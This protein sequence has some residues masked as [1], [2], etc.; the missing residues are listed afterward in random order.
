MIPIERT[1][2]Y[3]TYKQVFDAYKLALK[4][5]PDLSFKAHCRQ[6]SVPAYRLESWLNR[7]GIFINDLK[8]ESKD[9]AAAAALERM[10]RPAGTF[11]SVRPESEV[12]TGWR[13]MEIPRV[14]IYLPGKVR[15][16]LRKTSAASIIT[17]LSTYAEKGGR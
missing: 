2:R 10:Q 4:D 8:Q 17:L 7:Q 11:V 3:E 9:A 13:N 6:W 14:E 12:M 1:E 5:A 16:S 15:L